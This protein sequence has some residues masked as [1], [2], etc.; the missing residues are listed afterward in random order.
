MF[1][2]AQRSLWADVSGMTLFYSCWY[3][4]AR[5]YDSTA[6]Y[7]CYREHYVPLVPKNH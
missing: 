6:S 4:T 2:P 7:K 5:L 3:H 1:I